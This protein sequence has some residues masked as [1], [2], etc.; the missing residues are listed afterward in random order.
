MNKNLII[1]V[2]C[3]FVTVALQAQTGENKEEKIVFT[4]VDKEAKFPGGAEGW[5]RYLETNLNAGLGKYI[6]LKKGEKLG[7]QTVKVQF[8]VG[9]DGTISQVV[10]VNKNEVHHKL[11]DEGVRVIKEGPSWIP[12]EQNGRKVIYQAIQYITWQVAE[13]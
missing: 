9:K 12:A 1:L 2:T 6:K 7:Q 4:K 11:A 5:K 8:L 10:A 13:E 3:L